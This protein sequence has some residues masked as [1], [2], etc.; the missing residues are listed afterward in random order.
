MRPSAARS[1]CSSWAT[2]WCGSRTRAGKAGGVSSRRRWRSQV[3]QPSPVR[4]ESSPQRR[5]AAVAQPVRAAGLLDDAGQC[6]VMHV[7]DP[8][9][10]VVLDLEVETAEIPGEER[11]PRREVHGGG[12]LVLGPV[13]LD[14]VG[15]EELGLLDAMSELEDRGEDVAENEEGQGPEAGQRPGRVE[16]EGQGNRPGD[17]ERL[18]EQRDGER[19]PACARE[20]MPADPAREQVVEVVEE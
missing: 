1:V 10:Q 14:S 6:R 7:A 5:L 20:L 3:P 17:E 11:V 18:S 2:S 9:K 15:L 16:R 12:E 8:R 13:A 19:A 4:P